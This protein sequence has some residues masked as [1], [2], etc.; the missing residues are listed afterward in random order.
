MSVGAGDQEGI[1]ERESEHLLHEE[2]II[3]EI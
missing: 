2:I 3:G 1:K